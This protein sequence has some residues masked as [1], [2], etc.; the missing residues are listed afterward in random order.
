VY[1]GEWT[2]EIDVEMAVGEDGIPRAVRITNQ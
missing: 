1:P 2:E